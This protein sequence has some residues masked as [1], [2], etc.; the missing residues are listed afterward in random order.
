MTIILVLVVALALGAGYL[1]ERRKREAAD[2]RLDALEDRMGGAE[3]SVVRIDSDVDLLFEEV[4]P[5][6]EPETP[7]ASATEQPA[8][9]EPTGEKAPD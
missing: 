2:R 9:E 5:E 6:D 4:F 8:A 1:D 3:A 7:E